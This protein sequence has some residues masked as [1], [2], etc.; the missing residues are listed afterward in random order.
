MQTHTLTLQTDPSES[1]SKHPAAHAPR[2]VPAKPAPIS[3][4]R[5]PPGMPDR[6]KIHNPSSR[7]RGSGRR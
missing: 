3:R 7:H 4:P 1:D 6:G 5:P 2:P